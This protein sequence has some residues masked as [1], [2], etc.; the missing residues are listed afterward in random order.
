MRR[1][2]DSPPTLV[3]D[4]EA[5]ADGRVWRLCRGRHYQGSDDSVLTAARAAASRMGKVV[6][7]AR[8]DFGSTAGYMWV[9]FADAEV[10]YGRPCP[11]C[12]S[13][14]LIRSHPGF[15]TCPQCAAR[16][17]LLLGDGPRGPNLAEDHALAVEEDHDLPATEAPQAPASEDASE[18][19]RSSEP[20]R[21]ARQLPQIR[22]VPG[23]RSIE[24][25]EFYEQIHLKTGS[26][27]A[28]QSAFY[29]FGQGR[30]IKPTFLYV[31][32]FPAEGSDDHGDHRVTAVAARPYAAAVDF[33]ALSHWAHFEIRPPIEEDRDEL[34]PIHPYYS[35]NRATGAHVIPVAADAQPDSPP[36]LL[37]PSDSGTP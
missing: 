10:E 4:W 17:V 35:L 19:N 11:R 7:V 22:F 1:W 23:T 26:H 36:R 8:E 14:S 13:T 30:G 9:Q 27:P 24:R 18:A 25:L 21:V 33:R 15:A 34:T 5:V 28:G 16:L 37:P 29:G 32:F 31:E 2:R 3:I 12:G 20:P 6:S